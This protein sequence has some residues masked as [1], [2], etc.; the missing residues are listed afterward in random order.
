[1]LVLVCISDEYVGTVAGKS[2]LVT[3]SYKQMSARRIE[4]NPQ[5]VH[6]R[7]HNIRPHP[8]LFCIHI[9]IILAPAH[10][11]PSAPVFRQHVKLVLGSL[12]KDLDRHD[13]IL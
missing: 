10:S 6:H 5:K 9:Y 7:V 12:G 3:S 1:V 8:E 4:D 2:R 11:S 13:I